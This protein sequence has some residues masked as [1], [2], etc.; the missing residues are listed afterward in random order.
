MW[1]GYSYSSD[2][3]GGRR[4]RASSLMCP[5]MC[6][7]GSLQWGW[8]IVSASAQMRRRLRLC[9]SRRYHCSSFAGLD[10]GNQ[11]N[12]KPRYKPFE[13]RPRER[14]LP[15]HRF[16]LAWMHPP[17]PLVRSYA[18]RAA[19]RESG[20][21]QPGFEFEEAVTSKQ[22]RAWQHCWSI[23]P[24]KRGSGRRLS[25]TMQRQETGQREW[26]CYV[27][28]DAQPVLCE[29]TT[30]GED[31]MTHGNPRLSSV[32][33]VQHFL[34]QRGEEAPSEVTPQTSLCDNDN[35][36]ASV[37]LPTY[38]FGTCDRMVHGSAAGRSFKGQTSRP[39]PPHPP[40][41]SPPL[42]PESRR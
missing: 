32:C 21:R 2:H 14:L 33:R 16:P 11:R 40:P 35:G 12:F 15:K 39:P 10:P 3:L 31:I 25:A 42:L 19:L 41:P 38:P 36:D 9:C 37:D 34:C 13:R 7:H 4:D 17:L 5:L 28:T 18:L 24:S 6:R 23:F 29:E 30:P 27:P 1:R 26:I 22:P 20:E 8:V